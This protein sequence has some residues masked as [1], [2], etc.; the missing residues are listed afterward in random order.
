MKNLLLGFSLMFASGLLYANQ[1]VLDGRTYCRTVYSDGSFG[2]PKGKR[3]HCLI[4]RKGVVTN[5]RN[6]FF[7]NPP[8]SYPYQVKGLTV[9]FDD[10][11]YLLDTKGNSLTNEEGTVFVLQK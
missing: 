3:K 8:Q 6:T 5:T 11:Y 7:G 1:G 9:S 10:N 2:Q 4:F